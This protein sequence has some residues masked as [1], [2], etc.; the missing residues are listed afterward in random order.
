[1]SKIGKFEEITVTDRD[2]VQLAKRVLRMI[3]KEGYEVVSKIQKDKN[4][5]YTSVRYFAILK[6]PNKGA[7][8]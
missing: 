5:G 3:E 4:T 6:L 8:V 7:K 1:M 2:K